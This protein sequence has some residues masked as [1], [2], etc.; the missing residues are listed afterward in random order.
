[1]ALPAKPKKG[2]ASISVAL[3]AGFPRASITRL[4]WCERLTAWYQLRLPR[5]G[6]VGEYGDSVGE[7]GE[8][9][10]ELGGE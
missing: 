7:C 1:M 3:R 6:V 2:A 5:A 10:G 9:G 8:L 4:L